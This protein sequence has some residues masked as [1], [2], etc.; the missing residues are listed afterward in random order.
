MSFGEVKDSRES[1]FMN[2]EYCEKGSSD[3]AVGVD[4]KLDGIEDE[5][6]LS[7]NL[8]RLSKPLLDHLSCEVLAMAW[9]NGRQY[10]SAPW[11]R[12]QDVP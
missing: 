10:T 11:R 6:A 2:P 9:L 8:S 3:E 12:R 5:M 7:S 4:W 1:L